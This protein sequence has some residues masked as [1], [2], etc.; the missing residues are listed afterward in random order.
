MGDTRIKALALLSGGLD[1]TLA[2]KLILDQGIDVEALNFVTPFCLCGRGGCGSLE[3]AKKFHI[4][5]KTISL[6][7][8]YLKV[9][10]TP[11]HGYGKN[12]NPCLDCRIFMLKRAKQYAKQIGASLIFTGEVLDERPM[13]QHLIA[14]RTIEKEAALRGKILRPLSA[15]LLPETQ[16]ERKG[17]VDREKL[18]D[19]RGRSRKRQIQLVEAYG[20]T[21]YPCPSGG[22]L[23]TYREY[24]NKLRDLFEHRTKVSLRDVQLLRVGRHFRYGDNKI[25]VGRNESE[26]KILLKLKA[27][28]DYY[29]EAQIRESPITLL[30]GRKT[31]EALEKA[32]HLTAYY[33]DQKTGEVQVRFGKERL[34][35][36]LIVS[37]HSRGEHSIRAQTREIVNVA[38]GKVEK[39]IK[40]KNVVMASSKSGA[41]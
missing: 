20:I 26:N 15:K 37:V 9:V 1:S 6:G 8:E 18:L 5:L 3:T 39:L 4:P 33:S 24:A 2:V 25:V 34:G 27:E 41:R 17:W 29:F 38:S 32:A 31:K 7:E 30:Q 21:D 10:R 16:A 19:I 22:C 13:S 23:L 28:N 36:S 12:L 14:L 11:K 40:E 35:K